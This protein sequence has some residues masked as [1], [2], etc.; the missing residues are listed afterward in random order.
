MVG[1]GTLKNNRQKPTPTN[2][3]ISFR[4]GCQSRPAP[5]HITGSQ[6]VTNNSKGGRLWWRRKRNVPESMTTPPSR[7]HCS[8]FCDPG[9]GHW[10][11]WN[12]GSARLKRGCHFVGR[13]MRL[14]RRDPRS[15]QSHLEPAPL[16]R[17]R[18]APSDIANIRLID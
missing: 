6:N 9:S 3:R 14:F 10:F 16:P 15:S 7:L 4:R 1:T 13:K 12:R 18:D 5:T 17:L 8:V 11:N 2:R